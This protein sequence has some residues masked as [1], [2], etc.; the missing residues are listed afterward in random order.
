M[1]LR[2]LAAGEREDSIVKTRIGRRTVTKLPNNTHLSGGIL[3][4]TNRLDPVFEFPPT[5]L[6]INLWY[7]AVE[8]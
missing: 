6:P 5:S 3:A 2:V 4:N 7:E 8:R 1:R